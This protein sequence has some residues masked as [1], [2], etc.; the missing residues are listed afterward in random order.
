MSTSSLNLSKAPPTQPHLFSIE[1]LGPT[2]TFSGIQLFG[3][4]NN[5]LT[6]KHPL[7]HF[8]FWLCATIH[9]VHGIYLKFLNSSKGCILYIFISQD[10]PPNPLQMWFWG[11]WTFKPA[12][13]GKAWQRK[14]FHICC[15]FQVYCSCWTNSFH[16][17]HGYRIDKFLAKS[18]T[19]P[20]QQLAIFVIV[21]H[22]IIVPCSAINEWKPCGRRLELQQP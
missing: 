19:I 16:K 20:G 12:D 17:H 15:W 14:K 13:L 5:F 3:L 9:S 8:N 4:L 21:N 1:S 10:L 2:M 18:L 6:A 22:P 7:K 11:F